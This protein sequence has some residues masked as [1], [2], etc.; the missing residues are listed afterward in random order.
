MVTFDSEP[1]FESGTAR[2]LIGPIRLRHAIQHAPGAIGARL[3]SRGTEARQI[4]QSGELIANDP[5]ELRVRVDAIEKRLDGLSHTLVDNL[6][7]TWSDT[8]MTEVEA[9]VFT[10]VGARWKTA[11]RIEYLQVIS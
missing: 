9:D 4:K 7:R 1:L 2:F 3:D 10:R 6:G 11:Y 8:V 5:I